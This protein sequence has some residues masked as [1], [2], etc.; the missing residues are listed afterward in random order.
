M[1]QFIYHK[2]GNTE[3]QQKQALAFLL[4]QDSP[5]LASDG[6]L[7]GL[8]VSQTATAS[9]S[10]VVAAGSGASQDTVLNGAS[11]LVLDSPFTL[12]VLGANPVGGLPR[13]DVVVFDA[14]TVSSGAGGVR[15]LTGVPNASPT[16]PTVPATAVRLARLR[17][18]ASATT[19][20][21]SA[22]DDLRVFTALALNDSGLLAGFVTAATGWTVNT[23]QVRKVGRSVQLYITATRTGATLV[24]PASGDIG[25]VDVCTINSSAYFPSMPSGASVVVNGFMLGI[26]IWTDGHVSISSLP[27]SVNLTTGSIVSISASYFV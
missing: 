14:A 23:N 17:H 6:V 18:A 21:A 20:P 8:G 11:M 12:D 16:D 7:S 24:S 5:G 15:V 25:N 9:A 13:N 22:I 26:G 2:A 4:Q 1:T 3:A 10:V 27:P 19:V